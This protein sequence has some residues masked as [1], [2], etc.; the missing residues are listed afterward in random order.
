MSD[1]GGSRADFMRLWLEA[2]AEAMGDAQRGAAWDRAEA[3]FQAWTKLLEAAG[4]NA[5]ATATPFDPSEWLKP[6]DP[7][8]MLLMEGWLSGAGLGGLMGEAGRPVEEWRA[9]SKALERHRAMTGAAWL[10]AFREFAERARRAEADA[11]RLGKEPPDWSEMTDLWREI[12]DEEFA[13]T[14]RSEDYL[15]AQRALLEA[16]A[17]G[18]RRLRERIEEVA[19]LI[20]LPTRAEIDDMAEEIDRLRRAL[21]E[22]RG[23]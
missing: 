22:R 2:G 5:A 11:K 3:L 6:A 19:E 20:G 23:G 18:G 13:E 15:D 7:A 8:G 16:G 9:F 10:A 21:D 14:Q 4:P 1:G 17:D 12:A